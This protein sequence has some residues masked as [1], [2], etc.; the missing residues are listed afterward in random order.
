MKLY[1]S[2]GPNPQVVKTFI[3]EKGIDIPREEID[4]MKAE[5]R[6]E[7]YLSRNPA[8]QSPCLALDD[9]T[10]VSEITAICE[11]LEEVYPTP[12]L[13]GENPQQRAETRMWVRRID[14]SINEPMANAFRYSEGLRM[15]E[16]RIRVIPEAADGLKTLVREK[17]AWLDGLMG[18]NTW[19]CGDRFT[20]ADI[21]LHS[22]LGFAAQVGQPPQEELS[23]I[24]AWFKRASDRGKS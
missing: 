16:S 12:A 20:L 4:I 13:I 15:F 9:G 18:D 8:G 17:L 2:I 24:H 7:P 11:Y 22:F 10:H 3:A 21:M 19:I 5:N 6:S 14:L 1:Q 23:W